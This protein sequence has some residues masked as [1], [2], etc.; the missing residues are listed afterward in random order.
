VLDFVDSDPWASAMASGKGMG[1][2]Y[3]ISTFTNIYIQWIEY[4]IVL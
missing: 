3:A 2:T 4:L 1:F